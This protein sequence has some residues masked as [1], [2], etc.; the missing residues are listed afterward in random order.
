MSL[1]ASPIENLDTIVYS[2]PTVSY[3]NETTETDF[4]STLLYDGTL[5]HHTVNILIDLEDHDQNTTQ[6][7][8]TNTANETT[9]NTNIYQNHRHRQPVNSP[10]ANTLLPRLQRQNSVPFN[11]ELVI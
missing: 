10:N 11:I 1:T 5:F 7:N 9:N 6:N 8:N 3:I 4:N 2:Q